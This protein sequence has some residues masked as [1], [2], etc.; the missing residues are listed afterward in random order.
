M[1]DQLLNM[2]KGLAGDA[3]V[4]NPAVPNDKNN[5][6][7]ADAT[8]SV[9]DGLQGAIAGGGLQSVIS[10]LS[11]GGNVS[12]LAN[13]PIVGNIISNF[14]NKLTGNGV[15]GGAASSIAASLIPTV[16]S[17][18]VNNTTDPNNSAFSLE[19]ILHTLTGGQSTQVAQQQQAA[20]NSGFSFSNLL[21]QVTGGQGGGISSI[22]SQLAGGAQQSQAGGGLMNIIKGFL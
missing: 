15:A 12:A 22:V 1:L 16:M 7:I 8:H 21:S 4:N 17:K 11:G 9:A 18:L 6:V 13:N 3:V 2:V 10:M 14:T 19:G 20:G 5:A